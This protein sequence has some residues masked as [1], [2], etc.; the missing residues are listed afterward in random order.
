M[1]RLDR[2]GG[3][4]RQQGSGLKVALL[5]LVVLAA[6]LGMA[7]MAPAE[8]AAE[9]HGSAVRK[10][11]R[12]ATESSRSSRTKLEEGSSSSGDSG[13]ASV[14]IEGDVGTQ[15]HEVVFETVDG[16]DDDPSHDPEAAAAAAQAADA[17]AKRKAAEAEL[18]SVNDTPGEKYHV[19]CSLG[20]GYYTQW[21]SRVAYYWYKKVKEECERELGDKCAMGGYTRLLHS[22]A[23]DEFMEEIPTVVVDPLPPKYQEIAAGYVVLDRPYAFKQWVDKYIDTIPENYIWM[24]EPDHVFLK[25]PPLWATPQ[26][27]AAFPFFYIEPLQMKKIIDRFNPKG[28]AIEDFPPIGNSPVQI[29]KHQFAQLSDAWF[30]LS[31]AIKSDAEADREFGWVQEMYAYSIASAT[32]LDKPISYKLHVEMQLQPPWDAKLTAENGRPAFMIHF[33]YGNDYDEQGTFTPGKVGHWHWDK[34][35]WTDKYIPRDFPMPPE[36][37]NN[38]AV[39]ELIRRVNEA[40]GNLPRWAEFEGK[41]QTPAAGES[42]H[43]ADSGPPQPPRRSRSPLPPCMIGHDPRRLLK[44]ARGLK[45]NE[46]GGD[47]GTPQGTPRAQRRSS[48]MEAPLLPPSGGS[49]ADGPA[50]GDAAAWPQ[51]SEGQ[52]GA[53]PEAHA[54][55]QQHGDPHGHLW[56][57]ARRNVGLSYREDAPEGVDDGSHPYIVRSRIGMARQPAPSW[58]H[59]EGAQR[60][61]GGSAAVVAD[62]FV[63]MLTGKGLGTGAALRTPASLEGTEAPGMLAPPSDAKALF[64]MLTSSWLAVLLLGLPLGMWAGMTGGNPT[65]V[66]VSNFLALIPLALFLGEVTEDLAARFG[67]TIGGL[68]NATFGNVVELVL[69]VSAL[70]RGLYAVVAASLLG[71]ILSNLLLVLGTC[72]LFGGM[73][74]KEQRF[75][76]LAN[77]VSTSLLFLACIGILIPSTARMIYGK[78]VMTEQ[79]LLNLSHV[80]AITLVGIYLCY[81]LFQFGTHVDLF[82]PGNMTEGDEEEE[83]V[84]ALSLGGA[85]AAL[86]AITLIVTVC[87][88]FLTGAIEDVSASTGVNEAFLG[89]IVLPIAG[90]VTEHVTA[91]FVAV[92]NKMDLA[93]A[94]ALG[95]S[96][97]VAIFIV[98]LVVLIGW[99]MGEPFTLDFDSFAVLMLTASVILAYFVCSDGAS[100]WLLGLQLIATYCLVAFVFLLEK[101]T[102]VPGPSPPSPSAPLT[103]AGDGGSL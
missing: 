97:Q 67:D 30:N 10:E 87:S 59:T 24:G 32:T 41:L 2:R 21:Q 16:T 96:T 93:I 68:L 15:V 89:L 82:Q 71:S 35:D 37:C 7:N 52:G 61:P 50:Y 81:L 13:D 31:I 20:S 63:D 75:S 56:R 48:D 33:T 102:P 51:S 78:H 77:K 90:N 95:S 101:E 65:F 49:R 94:V 91:V 36:G 53:A 86:T 100:N 99:A 28:V 5:G 57:L 8:L 12:E 58:H 69:S 76:P 18:D 84:P 29:H 40:A 4:A 64:H 38:E 62:L 3:V 43:S 22:G 45:L 60:K 44:D 14:H 39:K 46:R 74:Y 42:T 70:R 6:V 80:I 17:E 27:P 79:V 47:G 88:E 83:E 25:A 34:R 9:L 66:F 92:K 55:Q 72:F 54:G 73:K 98:P 1:A 85:I 103:S 19:I 23:G 11:L 26:R